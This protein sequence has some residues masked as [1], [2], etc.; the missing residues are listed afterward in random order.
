[1]QYTPL[2][3]GR[4]EIRLLKIL[5]QEKP[6]EPV[7]QSPSQEVIQCMLEHVSL[8]D[9]TED[10]K[11]YF[12]QSGKEVYTIEAFWDRMRERYRAAGLLPI[13]HSEEP[14]DANLRAKECQ[15][16][17]LTVISCPGWGR[18][19]WGDYVALSYTWGTWENAKEI[20]VNGHMVK[21]TENLHAFLRQMCKTPMYPPGCGLWVDALCINQSDIDER[22]AQIKRMKLIYEQAFTA[23]AWLGKEADNSVL[24]F[25]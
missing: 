16:I 17:G 6:E 5:P 11:D 20:I 22:N 12:S 25:N 7:T 2:D 3:V 13:R 14:E 23:I 24:A 19:T 8:D 9:F 18:W 10:S 1:M 21:V 4:N 15:I